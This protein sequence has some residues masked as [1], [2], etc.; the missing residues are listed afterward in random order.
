MLNL[1]IYLIVKEFIFEP[2]E[3]GKVLRF[4]DFWL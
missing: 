1:E 2:G 3:L 4:V